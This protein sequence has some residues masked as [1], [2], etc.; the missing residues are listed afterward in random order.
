M[1]GTSKWKYAKIIPIPKTGNLSLPT[2]Y[3]PISLLCAC[4]KVFEHIIFKHISTFLNDNAIIDARQHGFRRGFSTVTQLVETAHDMATALDRQ[5]QI[6]L[7]FLYFEKA[8]DRVSHT[9]LLPK[10][11]PILKNDTLV[12]WIEAYL[13]IRKQ[14]VQINDTA[15]TPAN[16]DSGIPHGSVSGPLLFIV[17]ILL[18]IS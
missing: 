8:F 16:V 6:D 15:S 10:L 7:I 11:K 18:M 12:K 2:S 1:R 5:T 13:S 14:C 17:F 4:A 3:R 9:K